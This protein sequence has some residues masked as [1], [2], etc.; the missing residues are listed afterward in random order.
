M[1]KAPERDGRAGRVSPWPYVITG[2]LLIIVPALG[3][4]GSRWY[5]GYLRMKAEAEACF[6]T[7][8]AE[9]DVRTKRTHNNVD[10]VVVSPDGMRGLSI[11]LH[12]VVRL[13]DLDAKREI[14]ALSP[15]DLGCLEING[16]AFAPDGQ[17]ILLGGYPPLLTLC[18][19]ESGRTLR[20]AVV[21]SIMEPGRRRPRELA[22]I[23]L[24][25]S[26]VA[27][28]ERALIAEET[29]LIR[30]WDL[31]ESEVLREF[32][33]HKGSVHALR[34]SP[35]GSRAISGGHDR[36]VRLW[37]LA[38]G[39]ELAQLTGHKNIVFD[40][41]F[42]PDGRH[43]LSGGG[44]NVAILWDLGN[45]REVRRFT[46][47][48]ESVESVAFVAGRKTPGLPSH[49]LSGSRDGTIRLWDVGS[50]ELVGTY[51]PPRAE[52]EIVWHWVFS[53]AVSNELSIFM[54]GEKRTTPGGGEPALYLWRLP[55]ERELRLLGT[56][57]E[58]TAGGR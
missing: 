43:A 35:D 54:A 1:P 24:D 57:E 6:T 16:A 17:R 20:Q 25:I 3:Y 47:H 13:F 28:D 26:P 53:V 10:R 30:L 34:F 4:L 2:L 49:F 23:A 38:S 5:F 51:V 45:G 58:R 52:G 18:E 12:G 21:P 8:L 41:I 32:R 9:F 56:Q 50:G 39:R 36:T 15:R 40:V 31:K 44:D 29:G 27:G 22:I 37:D 19:I 11:D 7:P 33:G 48:T 55:N 42:A 46:G 14:W